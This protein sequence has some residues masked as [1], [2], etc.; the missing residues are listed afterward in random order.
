[1]EHIII[2]QGKLKLMLTKDDLDKYELGGEIS[3]EN[4][5][6]GSSIRNLLEDAGR[7][8]GFD[9]SSE[10]AFVQIYPSRDGGAEVYITCLTK[11]GAAFNEGKKIEREYVFVFDDFNLMLE[12]CSKISDDNITGNSSAW[13][14]D[15]KYYL[16]IC[17]SDYSLNGI[18]GLMSRYAKLVDSPF[19]PSYLKE[20]CKCFIESKAINH[21]LQI[22]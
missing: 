8:T 21:L 2:S 16:Y 1:M 3:G 4:T 5:P 6:S 17:E 22:A 11:K 18:I 10:K 12:A 9:I 19:M 20:H 14:L 13:H 15:G 7:A